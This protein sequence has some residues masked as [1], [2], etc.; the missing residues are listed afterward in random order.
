M[1]CA[2]WFLVCG[3]WCLVV[4]VCGCSVCCLVVGVFGDGVW[5]LLLL[6]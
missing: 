6:L 4:A 5:L 1:L 3:D 2:V